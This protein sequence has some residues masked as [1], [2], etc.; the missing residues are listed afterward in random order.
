MTEKERKRQAAFRS[1]TLRIGMLVSRRRAEDLSRRFGLIGPDYDDVW[2]VP[3]LADPNDI[4]WE[5]ED[6]EAFKAAERQST[7]KATRAL[8]FVLVNHTLYRR[9]FG[10]GPWGAEPPEKKAGDSERSASAQREIPA[11]PDM[12]PGLK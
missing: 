12:Q 2:F 4:Q 11:Q 3:V 1:G 9:L 7:R 10:T 5:D 6:L 8:A